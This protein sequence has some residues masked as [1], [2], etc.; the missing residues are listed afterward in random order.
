MKMPGSFDINLTYY[1]VW[2]I[3]SQVNYKASFI[4]SRVNLIETKE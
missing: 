2:F 3:I 1:N 4:N